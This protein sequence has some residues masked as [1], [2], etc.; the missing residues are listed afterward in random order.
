MKFWRYHAH[1]PRAVWCGRAAAEPLAQLHRA[2]DS[3]SGP[4][5]S[6]L[7]RR[8]RRTGE[9]LADPATQARFPAADGV[10]LLRTY[11][12]IMSSLERRTLERRALHGDP[13][14]GNLLVSGEG[15]TMIDFESVCSGPQ[16]WD[17][18]ALPGHG[19][20]VLTVDEELLM[21]LRRLRSL[22]VAV[23]CSLRRSRSN[24]LESAGRMHLE[25]LR[26]AC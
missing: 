21:L 10:F 24:E 1:D 25:L 8:V 18:S 20:G 16:E 19:A 22:C 14:R 3:Y 2:L 17:L 13:H 11:V 5:A 4:L 12:S 26:Q 7:E 15:Y 23:W 9:V 6:F